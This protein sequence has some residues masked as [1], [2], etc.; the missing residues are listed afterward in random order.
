VE[1]NQR[2]ADLRK[3]LEHEWAQAGRFFYEM[4]LLSHNDGRM[5][6]QAIV[7]TPTGNIYQVLVV[8]PSDYPRSLPQVYPVPRLPGPHVNSDGS[9][10]LRLP[11]D[12]AGAG[13]TI[14]VALLC[15]AAQWL[16]AHEYWLEH[17]VWMGGE[18]PGAAT[19][20]QDTA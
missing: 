7:P 8:Y 5:L 16:A 1:S 9:M 20:A 15:L 13:R 12:Q 4:R 6:L 3:A 19:D 10:D 2:Q 11:A 17:G 14:M 18:C